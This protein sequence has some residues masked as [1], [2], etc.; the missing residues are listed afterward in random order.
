MDK[1]HYLHFGKILYS[2]HKSTGDVHLL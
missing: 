2:H 1:T